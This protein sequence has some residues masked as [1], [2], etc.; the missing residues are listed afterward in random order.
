MNDSNPVAYPQL[1]GKT[2]LFGHQ[3]VGQ[4][5]IDGLL[6]HADRFPGIQAIALA[7]LADSPQPGMLIHTP[8]GVNTQ[9]LSKLAGFA[10]I[11]QSGL[12]APVDLALMKFCYIDINENTD[13]DQ[14]FGQYR[15]HLDQLQDTLPDTRLLHITVPLRTIASGP[16]IW[17]REWL[18]RTNHSK[19]ANIRRNEFN[20]RLIDCYGEDGVFDLAAGEATLESGRA[21][22]FSYGDRSLKYY[23][24]ADEFSSDGGHLNARGQL[25]LAAD[26]LQFLER[27]A[28]DS[29]ASGA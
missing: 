10:E 17:M 14:L 24:L 19:L 3:S 13:I 21:R 1:S 9:P 16:S 23:A 11:L 7:D 29:K 2:V 28:A 27:A 26:L 12:P 8:V 5:I 22:H 20:Q 6:G 15:E 18:G 4:N 25:K